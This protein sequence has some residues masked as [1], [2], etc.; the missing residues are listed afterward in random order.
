M[1]KKDIEAIADPV[2]R[3]TAIRELHAAMLSFEEAQRFRMP[4][5][6]RALSTTGVVAFFAMMVATVIQT[7]SSSQRL[8]EAE[9]AQQSMMRVQEQSEAISAD[10][11]IAR[12]AS[13]ASARCFEE[14]YDQ[15]Q[16]VGEGFRAACRVAITFYRGTKPLEGVSLDEYL[17]WAMVAE[18]WDAVKEIADRIGVPTGGPPVQRYVWPAYADYYS[19]LTA[20]AQALLREAR[21]RDVFDEICE[22][23][24]PVALHALV[25]AV[26]T[27]IDESRELLESW[28]VDD[29]GRRSGESRQRLVARIGTRVARLRNLKRAYSHASR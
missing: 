11:R 13:F 28:Q 5:F 17:H 22:H 9:V 20:Q 7:H 19:G 15:G 10:L 14:F 29:L 21:E 23:M 6:E 27:E 16:P 1:R 3:A 2:A 4:W 8:L 26:E 24:S 18:D 25:S 12:Q